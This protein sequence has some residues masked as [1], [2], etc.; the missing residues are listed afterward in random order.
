MPNL[1]KGLQ[2]YVQE[3]FRSFHTPGHKGKMEFFPD[4]DFPGWDLTELPGLDMLHVPVGII[5]AA[6][7]RA[8]AIFGAEETFFLVNGGTAGNQAMLLGLGQGQGKVLV[9]RQ[10]HRSLMSALVLTGLVPEYLPP[11]IHPEFNLPLGFDVRESLLKLETAST[12]HFTYPSY[13]GTTIDL[14]FL[15]AERDNRFSSTMI[16]VDQAHGAH[17][18]HN[19][20][21]PSA[22]RLGADIVLHSTHK[23]LSALTQ[24][25]MLHI[26]GPRVRR[27]RLRQALELLQSSSPSYLLLASLESAGEFASE[28]YRWDRLHEEVLELRR[29]VKGLRILTEEDAG[30]YGIEQV[31]WS[32][33]LVNTSVLGVSAAECVDELRRTWKIEPELWDE[34]NILFVLGIGNMP[35]DIRVLSRGLQNLIK[36]RKTGSFSRLNIHRFAYPPLPPLRMTPREA[37]LAPKQEITLRESLGR[38]SGETI[39][40]YPPGVPLVVMGEEITSEVLEALKDR[41]IRWQ[42]W[43]GFARQT[44]MVVDEA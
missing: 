6:Q 39:S 13:F 9:E 17:Y 8:A 30:Q 31:D 29:N 38:I 43:E 16:L 40:P 20:F 19:L 33:I 14:R 10:A 42:G 24:A 18:L 11:V 41:E 5:A 15:L 32:K 12:W 25:A 37:C 2:H 1:H 21:P 4:L 26:Q 34:E 22:L 44:L 3:G 23:T 27:A 35:E 28:R 36:L 7:K